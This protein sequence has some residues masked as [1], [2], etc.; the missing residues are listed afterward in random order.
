MNLIFFNRLQGRT[1]C[2]NLAHPLTLVASLAAVG[3]FIGGV[4]YAGQSLGRYQTNSLWQKRVAP[5]I[6]QREQAAD[7]LKAQL[8]ARIDALALKTGTLDANLLRL[9]ALGKRLAEMADIKSSEFDFDRD[10]PQG[11]P[12]SGTAGRGVELAVVDSQLSTL[13]RTID[14]RTA[15]MSALEK[16][17]LGRQLQELTLPSG[18]PV[19]EGYI[20]SSFGE[21]M[22]PFN[23]EEAFHK[24]ID[25]AAP[26]GA[27]VSAV[28]DGIVTWAG[29]RN[30]FGVLVEVSHGNGY[31][32]RYAHNSRALVKVGETVQRGEALAVVGSTGRSTGPHVHF[33]V[34]KNAVAI[35]PMSFIGR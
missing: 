6:E 14:F 32:T 10:P 7:S 11:G 18:R 35:N 3:L 16:L 15:Q 4:F 20:S 22:D 25:F 17:L 13:Q 29:A 12:E 5:T 34:L 21:R 8:Q 23:G 24:G 1:R 2:L 33:E 30:G 26:A 28:A 31:V 19:H 9:N 27:D